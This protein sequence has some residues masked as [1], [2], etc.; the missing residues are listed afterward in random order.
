[1]NNL[2][3]TIR[4]QCKGNIEKFATYVATLLLRLAKNEVTDAQAFEKVDEVLINASCTVSNSE[5]VVYKQVNA[6]NLDVSK[7]TIKAREEYCTLVTNNTWTKNTHHKNTQHRN[8]RHKQRPTNI[9]ALAAS[10]SQDNEITKLKLELKNTKKENL[11][12]RQNSKQ[13][14]NPTKAASLRQYSWDIQ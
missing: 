10:T 1:M 8:D 7:P 12:L 13:P 6:S 5:I 4:H 9:A 11:T 2:P 14:N 3:S